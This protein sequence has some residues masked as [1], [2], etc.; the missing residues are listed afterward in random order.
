MTVLFC[1][2]KNNLGECSFLLHYQSEAGSRE[3]PVGKQAS[4]CST[5][6]PSAVPKA[7]KYTSGCKISSLVSLQVAVVPTQTMYLQLLTF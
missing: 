5:F 6:D 3:S 2:F 4:L 7:I 1:N